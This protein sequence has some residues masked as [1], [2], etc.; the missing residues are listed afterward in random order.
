MKIDSI[1]ETFTTPT[2]DPVGNQSQQ[3]PKF[4]RSDKFL[5]EEN[6][7]E[8]TSGSIA[9]VDSP[10][11]GMQRRGKGSMFQGI[12]TSKKFAN[13]ATVK[14][15]N[16]FAEYNDEAGMFKNNLQT[17]QRVSRH[18]E[19]AIS[20]NENLPEWCQEKVA[21]AKGMI[22]AV[23][24]YMISQHENGDV[25]TI[26]EGELK[27]DDLILGPGK[28]RKVKPG[29]HGK[30]D[31]PKFRSYVP[32]FKASGMFV[33]DKRGNGVCECADHDMAPIV[34]KALNGYASVSESNDMSDFFKNL[35]KTNPRFKNLR[36]HGDPE[37]DE[38]RRQD[39]IERDKRR[40][41][42]EIQSKKQH[43]ANK[44]KY[45]EQAQELKAWLNA[46]DNDQ[47]AD[48]YGTWKEWSEK[49]QQYNRLVRL[50]QSIDEKTL[51]EGTDTDDLANA[52]YYRLER[53]Y[54]NI[55]SRY[56][57]E[58]VAD[59]IMNV[60]EF[61]GGSDEIGTSDISIMCRQV[62]DQLKRHVNNE[63]ANPAQQ[64]AIAIN[65][66][67]RHQKPKSE[68]VDEE[69]SPEVLAK[70]NKPT[71]DYYTKNPH[72]TGEKEIVSVGK[73]ARATKVRP[74][75]APA[76]VTKKSVDPVAKASSSFNKWV[77]QFKEDEGQVDEKSKSQA[78]FRTMAAVAHNPEFAKK[79]GIKPSVGK[80]FHKADKKQDYKDLPDR[81]EE[82]QKGLW[83]NIHAKRER[84]K[85]GS[86]EHMRKPGSKGA[87]T[88]D[89]LRKSAK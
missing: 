71:R 55:I 31:Q 38:L 59:A 42:Q 82:E 86:G 66:K 51:E 67:K 32:P 3:A 20:D 8:T 28:G 69:Y 6:L 37:H 87:P 68:G 5:E 52:I 57:H 22:V 83:A 63:A 36:I 14:E 26:D 30:G 34:A 7:D 45:V 1:L 44:D 18:L 10:V 72:M 43:L 24:D 15:D 33:S 41:E 48:H 74:M 27:E 88:A 39:Q 25:H 46:H 19:K 61:H 16:D 73:G 65:M 80:E 78:Q 60:A 79:V 53:Q 50:I 35:Q 40:Q 64:A 81:V 85:H 49:S 75:N 58:I 23:M 62:V 70:M 89:A 9:S 17:V 21:A 11:G 56:G 29:L 84:I 13:S 54:P 76:P 4:S 47:Y 77:S 2:T 12:K